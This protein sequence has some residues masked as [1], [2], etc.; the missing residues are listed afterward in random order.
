MI[1]S[2]DAKKPSDKI[3]HPFMIKKISANTE[4]MCSNIKK[5]IYAKSTTNSILNSENVKDLL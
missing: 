3:H 1:I 2:I 5:A 4:E